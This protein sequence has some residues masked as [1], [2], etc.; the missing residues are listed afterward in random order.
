VGTQLPDT[1]RNLVSRT[2]RLNQ[3]LVG[4]AVGFLIS[5][6]AEQQQ[7]G[8]QTTITV[9]GEGAAAQRIQNTTTT[10]QRITPQEAATGGGQGAAGPT[11]AL[12]LRGLLLSPDERLNALT[13]LGEPRKVE[14]ATALLTQLDLRRRQV[15]VNVKIVDVNLLGTDAFNSSF[16]FRNR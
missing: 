2:L 16:S 9:V 7:V 11:G 4:Q 1:A 8:T 12:V 3:T 14:I 10:V 6:G 5:Q 15:A 13:L